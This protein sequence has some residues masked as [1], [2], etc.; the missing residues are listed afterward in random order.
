[1]YADI[2]LPLPL[3]GLFTYS[4][5]ATIAQEVKLGMRV[6]V[7]FGRSKQYVGVIAKI[8]NTKPEGYQVKDILQLMDKEPILLPQ[9][10]RLWSWIADYYMSPI[11]EVYKAALPAGLKAEEGYR[12]KTE[13][14]IRLTPKFQ[15]EQAL[16]VALDVLRRADK[17][18]Q[19]FTAYLQLSGWDVAFSGERTSESVEC[20]V[21]SVEFATAS[22][23][24]ETGA[25]A[26][27]TLSTLN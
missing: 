16:H 15:S 2:I 1:M 22:G 12:P 21:Q 19:V 5:P 24:D 26:N 13:T 10:Y 25:V 18:L 7:P 3:D 11:G 4:V 20:R 8:H 14:Y 17:Q 23:I 6:L 9:Q 27:S